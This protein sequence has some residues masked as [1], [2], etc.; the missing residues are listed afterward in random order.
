M[1]ATALERGVVRRDHVMIEES[2]HTCRTDLDESWLVTRF[3]NV[4]L[5]S[6]TVG[7]IVIGLSGIAVPAL[8]ASQDHST[9][10]IESIQLTVPSGRGAQFSLE[11]LAS[12]QIGDALLIVKNVGT[13]SAR[14]TGVG[15]DVPSTAKPTRDQTGYRVQA[16]R[17]G[18]TT[19][20]IA[21]SFRLAAIPQS[22]PLY[23][24]GAVLKPF[25]VSRRW[26]AIIAR[27]SVRT[28]HRHG[29]VIRG[30][31]VSL[32]EGKTTSHLFFPQVVRLPKDSC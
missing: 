11:S 16:I 22:T 26:Y 24:D 28:V 8:S 1:L 21:A 7:A 23:A 4:L 32:V 12:C 17:P 18:S 15:M 5:R 9:K 13:R 6:L 19:G 3:R 14:I 2:W 25:T 10:P 27:T 31:M 30:M 20:E 29:W